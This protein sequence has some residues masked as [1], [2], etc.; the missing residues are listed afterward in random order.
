MKFIRYSIN[1]LRLT[2]ISAAV[3]LILLASMTATAKVAHA[4]GVVQQNLR[5]ESELPWLFAV[6]MITW[7]VFFGYI[8][9]ISRRQRE[10]SKEIEAL[11]RA[12]ADRESKS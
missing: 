4:S 12:L 2:G 3:A 9:M 7:A 5:G 6:Y 1:L 8:F 10:M 11:K